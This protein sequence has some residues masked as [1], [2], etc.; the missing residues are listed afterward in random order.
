[1]ADEN[2]DTNSSKPAGRVIANLSSIMGQQSGQLSPA[3][4]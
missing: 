4:C 1:M 2:G 3:A